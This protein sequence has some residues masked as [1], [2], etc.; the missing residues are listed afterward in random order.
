MGYTE[1]II[2]IEMKNYRM[3]MKNYTTHCECGGETCL[4]DS[5]LRLGTIKRR[6]RCLKCGSS[7]ITFEITAKKAGTPARVRSEMLRDDIRKEL[8]LL[9]IKILNIL[10]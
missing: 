6:R 2:R 7:F 8:E 5:H 1:G 9:F 3:E 10:E 4:I